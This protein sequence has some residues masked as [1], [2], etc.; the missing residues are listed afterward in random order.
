MEISMEVPQETKNKIAIE[1]C[2]TTLG[3]I[4]EGTFINIQERYLHTY[5]YSS[6]IYN[7]QEMEPV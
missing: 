3:H 5:V 4:S 7:S 6:T 1:S 2:Y